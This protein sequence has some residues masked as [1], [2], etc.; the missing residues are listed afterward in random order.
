MTPLPPQ[1]ADRIKWMTRRILRLLFFTALLSILLVLFSLLVAG[2]PDSLTARLEKKI[3]AAGIP[4]KFDSVRLSLHRGW[5]LKNARLYSRSPD[6]LNPRFRTGK[7]YLFLWPEQWRQLDE[8][9]WQIRLFARNLDLSLGRAWDNA[10]PPEHPFQTVNKIRAA[11]T[12]GPQ[13]VRLHRAEIHWD[14]LRVYTRGTFTFSKEKQRPLISRIGPY[15][16]NAA[17]FLNTLRFEQPPTLHLDVALDTDRPENNR[18]TGRADAGGLVWNKQVFPALE[19]AVSTQN[20]ILRVDPFTLTGRSNAQLRVRGSYRWSSRLTRLEIENTLSADET[21]ALLPE[22]MRTDIDRAGLQFSGPLRFSAELGPAAPDQLLQNLTARIRQVRLQHN[23]LHIDPLSCRLTR[24][25]DRLAISN[26][27]ARLDSGPLEGRLHLN[28]TNRAWTANIQARCDPRPAGALGSDA[29]RRFLNRLEFTNQPPRIQL[30]LSQP[31]AGANLN[32]RG[33]VSAESFRCGQ[34][35]IGTLETTMYYTNRVLT[36]HPLRVQRNTRRFEGQ[37][38]IDFVRDLAFFN[39]TNTFSPLDITHALLPDKKTVFE[40]FRFDGPLRA[41]GSGQ[42]DYH[43]K[44]N[45]SFDINFQGQ[46]IGFDRIQTDRLRA[47]LLGDGTRLDVLNAFVEL[48]GGTATGSARFDLFD[49]DGTSPYRMD[50][51]FKRL[52][53]ARLL[54]ADKTSQKQAQG[55]L[56]GSLACRADAVDGFWASVTGGGH[57]AIREGRLADVP[58]FG[59]FSRLMRISFPAFNFFSLNTFT[60]DYTLKN[61]AVHSDSALLSGPLLSARGNGSWSPD[62]GLDFVVRVEPLTQTDADKGWHQ[63]YLWAADILQKG[64]SPLFRLLEFKLEG[65]LD[66]PEWRFINLP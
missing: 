62:N 35:P 41:A 24:S 1:R 39:A 4:L 28:L 48:F 12:A 46:N 64:T 51:R 18:I 40:R 54:P 34:T 53:I 23:N 45:H 25:G 63:V 17:R 16:A 9:E 27:Q 38:Q 31:C 11:L 13:H 6:D 44:T 7:L 65:T 32:F 43:S 8:T 30:T 37:M 3:N 15:A 58:L 20:G 57:A 29:L 47:R 42:F 19:A 21:A 56:S 50:S 14:N 10:L 55:R 26:L 61:G 60:A 2:L 66:Q 33:T 36:L 49:E 22:S 5:V 59:G 52:D